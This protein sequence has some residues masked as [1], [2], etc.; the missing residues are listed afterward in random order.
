MVQ[1]GINQALRE[2]GGAVL[3]VAPGYS[4]LPLN[5]CDVLWYRFGNGFPDQ[6]KV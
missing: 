3:I 1:P 5:Q 4:A 2:A 6:R